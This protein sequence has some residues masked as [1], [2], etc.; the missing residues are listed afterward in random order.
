MR[1]ESAGNSLCFPGGQ[2]GIQ[3][4]VAECEGAPSTQQGGWAL[5]GHI[6]SESLHHLIDDDFQVTLNGHV[7]LS[8]FMYFA[9]L[10]P[11]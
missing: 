5:W 7:F 3:Q 4:N 8:I 2:Q 10:E 6:L 11:I 9:N 1:G